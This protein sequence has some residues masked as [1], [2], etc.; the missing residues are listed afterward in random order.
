MSKHPK[1]THLLQPKHFERRKGSVSS[2]I[3][4]NIKDNNP[5]G[6]K[7]KEPSWGPEEEGRLPEVVLNSEHCN[8]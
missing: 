3:V 2:G 8:F 7:A 6:L 1:V 4:S 5:Q